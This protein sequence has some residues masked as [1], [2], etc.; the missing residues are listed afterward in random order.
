MYLASRY[1]MRV[2]EERHIEMKRIQRL[3][4]HVFIIFQ[5]RTNLLRMPV[6]RCVNWRPMKY[7]VVQMK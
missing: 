4:G 2:A 1:V 6:S 7:E 5:S 3:A